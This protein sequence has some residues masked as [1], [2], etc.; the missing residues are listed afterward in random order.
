MPREQPS[1]LRWCITVHDECVS[2]CFDTRA[3]IRIAK[4]RWKRPENPTVIRAPRCHCH[5]CRVRQMS[6]QLQMS[7]EM[8]IFFFFSQLFQFYLFFHH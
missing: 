3:D 4:L 5:V 8:K 6:M 1:R 2:Y 7:E